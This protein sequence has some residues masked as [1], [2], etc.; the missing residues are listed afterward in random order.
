MKEGKGFAAILDPLRED[1]PNAIA[2][3]LTA[4]MQVK[5]VTGDN[6]E[7][8][9]EIARQIGLWNKYFNHRNCI[10]DFLARLFT[11]HASR[12]GNR[13]LRTIGV[14][15]CIRHVT[16]LEFVQRSLLG[17]EAVSFYRFVK[18]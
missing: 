10:F 2:T 5:I 17:V 11:S 3:C 15:C 12:W 13:F 4:G 8:A 18:K 14:F 6:S 16:I 7:T 1:V 9:K